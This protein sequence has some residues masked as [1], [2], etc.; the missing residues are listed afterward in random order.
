M[1]GNRSL[2]DLEFQLPVY[3]IAILKCIFDGMTDVL[4]MSLKM[5]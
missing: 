3:V 4:L 2:L 1:D 5:Q